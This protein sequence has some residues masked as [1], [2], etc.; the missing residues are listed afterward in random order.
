[1]IIQNTI[2]MSNITSDVRDFDLQIDFHGRQLPFYS[3]GYE[4]EFDEALPVERSILFMDK[5]TSLA[6]T[7][8]RE[9]KVEE[10]SQY[11]K[12]PFVQ[13]KN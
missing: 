8:M 5:F 2:N 7:N 13:D 4:K 9:L 11:I 6:E 1:M 12:I 10:N 3:F